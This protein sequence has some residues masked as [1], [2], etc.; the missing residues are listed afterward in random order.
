MIIPEKDRNEE[1]YFEFSANTKISYGHYTKSQFVVLHA[2]AIPGYKITDVKLKCNTCGPGR[3]CWDENL[4]PKFE[5][6]KEKE[7]LIIWPTVKPIAYF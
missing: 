3:P 6:Y 7:L 2:G 1:G 5:H 4:A